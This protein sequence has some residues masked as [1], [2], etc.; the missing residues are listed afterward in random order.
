MIPA[1]VKKTNKQGGVLQI[2]LGTG[3][4]LA[5]GSQARG[6]A[7]HQ[8]THLFSSPYIHGRKCLFPLCIPRTQTGPPHAPFRRSASLWSHSPFSPLFGSILSALSFF[9]KRRLGGNELGLVIQLVAFPQRGPFFLQPSFHI[10]LSG[11]SACTG[12]DARC[13]EMVQVG[14]QSGNMFLSLVAAFPS[15]GICSKE[16]HFTR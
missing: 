14:K 15:A 3:G 12:A 7:G 16:T 13:S 8:L 1:L 10:E 5:Q 9:L 2:Y 6:L 11:R 4:G